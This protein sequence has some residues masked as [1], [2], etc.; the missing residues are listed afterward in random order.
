MNKSVIKKAIIIISLL[1]NIVAIFIIALEFFGIRY[2][3]VQKMRTPIGCNYPIVRTIGWVTDKK[4]EPVELSALFNHENFNLFN[5]KSSIKINTKIKVFNDKGMW[6]ER[7][8]EVFIN[9][10]YINEDGK[11]IGQIELTP[12]FKSVQD[13][14]RDFFNVYK[15][16]LNE[17][18]ENRNWGPNY[19]RI[20]IGNKTVN[21]ETLQRK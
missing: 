14:N 13:K 7:I 1:L 3:V 16:A 2:W 8:E 11:Y 20:Q 17:P 4:W 12:R 21:L 10:R 6:T 9:Q 5:S 18:I 15:I 19:Y